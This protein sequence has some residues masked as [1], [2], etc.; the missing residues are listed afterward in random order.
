MKKQKL[1]NRLKITPEK[2]ALARQK[3]EETP[4][5]KGDLRALLIAAFI[6][7]VLPTIGVL[8]VLAFIMWL[9]FFAGR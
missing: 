8:A 5:E 7:F 3:L 1:L 2:E 9:I 6:M 4:L